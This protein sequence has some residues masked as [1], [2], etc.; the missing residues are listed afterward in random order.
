M[1]AIYVT[2][3]LTSSSNVILC[4]KGCISVIVVE[5][6]GPESDLP[7]MVMIPRW[8]KSLPGGRSTSRSAIHPHGFRTM[9]KRRSFGIGWMQQRATSVFESAHYRR[10]EVSLNEKPMLYSRGNPEGISCGFINLGSLEFFGNL[11]V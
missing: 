3:R 8:H 7:R 6:F 9:V 10:F 1:P 5:L 11:D 4:K 2:P